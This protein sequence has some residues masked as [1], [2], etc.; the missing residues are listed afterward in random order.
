[1]TAAYG[2]GFKKKS[3]LK[4]K[5]GC[6]GLNFYGLP[7]NY[8]GNLVENIWWKTLFLQFRFHKQKSMNVLKIF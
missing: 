1:M 5:L 3:I 8:G 7:G 4:H 6:S 2:H